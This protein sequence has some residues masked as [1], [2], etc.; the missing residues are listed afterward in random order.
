[1]KQSIAELLRERAKVWVDRTSIEE[2]ASLLPASVFLNSAGPEPPGPKRRKSREKRAASKPRRIARKVRHVLTAEEGTLI[3]KRLE[4]VKA[5]SPE[6][7]QLRDELCRKLGIK[8]R[9]V[10][11]ALGGAGKHRK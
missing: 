11:G 2:L 3:R 10:T 7:K 4:G 5:G 1:M 9:Q 8:P 6:F